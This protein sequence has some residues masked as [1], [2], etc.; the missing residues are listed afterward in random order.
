MG[1]DKPKGDAYKVFTESELTERNKDLSEVVYLNMNSWVYA[2]PASYYKESHPGGPKAILSVKGPEDC[3][4]FFDTTR[5]GQGHSDMAR[6]VLGAF[7][8][9]HLGEVAPSIGPG[10]R[11]KNQRT[12]LQTVK[13]LFFLLCVFLAHAAVFYL[14]TGNSAEKP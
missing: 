10:E 8:E 5:G 6:K 7:L 11:K 14:V 9:G 12:V 13:E 4:K 1:M 2:V 3:S